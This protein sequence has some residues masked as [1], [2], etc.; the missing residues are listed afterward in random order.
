M[1][2]NSRLCQLLLAM[3]LI[4]SASVHAQLPA[5]TEVRNIAQ[6]S[7]SGTMEAT[8]DWLTLSLSVTKEGGDANAVQVY[9]RQATETALAKV[10]ASAQAGGI[11]VHTGAFSLQPRYSNDGKLNGWV[12]TSELVLE[13]NDFARISAAATNAQPMTI[14]NLAFSLSRQARTQLEGQA[15]TLAIQSF[16]AKAADIARDFG[17]QDYVLREVS[18]SAMDQSP[19]PRPRMMAMSSRAVMADAAPI[20]LESGKSLVVVTV[21]GAIQLK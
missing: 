10:R 5:S 14:N 7:A 11:E 8:Q 16:K 1:R 12:G 21:S 2:I 13:G 6:L 20:P 15:Q 17:F 9:L 3:G 18:V 19:G 4:A